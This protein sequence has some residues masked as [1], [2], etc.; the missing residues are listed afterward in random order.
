MITRQ[1]ATHELAR[2]LGRK[3]TRNH[4]PSACEPE[5][6]SLRG[7][8]G[9]CQLEVRRR[10]TKL[11][12]IDRPEIGDRSGQTLAELNARRPSQPCLRERDVWTALFRVVGG[13]RLVD[14]FRFSADELQRQLGQQL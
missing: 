7:K 4:D 9:K 3:P 2:E 12:Q 1:Q 14:D 10:R 11:R 5:T 8:S 13:T 6:A